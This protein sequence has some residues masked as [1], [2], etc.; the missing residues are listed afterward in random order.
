M[1][2]VPARALGAP[3]GWLSAGQGCWRPGQMER[4][5][6]QAGLRP[7]AAPCASGRVAVPVSACFRPLPGLSLQPRTW[8]ARTSRSR[9]SAL[10]ALPPAMLSS[11]WPRPAGSL[12]G[13]QHRPPDRRVVVAESMALA[14][15]SRFS[16][17]WL[18]CG[19]TACAKRN[20][21]RPARS[22]RTARSR[23]WR[24]R[25]AWHLARKPVARR[26]RPEHP[27]RLRARRVTRLKR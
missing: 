11:W 17:R 18:R 7:W 5:S 27:T 15:R 1:Q 10:Q 19:P 3:P 8:R 26:W 16:A 20:R 24:A 4:P 25:S 9:F 2:R 13:L 12:E 22:P 6:G 23:R 14:P 21:P